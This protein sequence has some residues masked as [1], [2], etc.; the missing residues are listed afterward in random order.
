[1]SKVKRK[2]AD[3]S[4]ACRL[5]IEFHPHKPVLGPSIRC[6]GR[7]RLRQMYQATRYQ[8]TA[9]VVILTV[10]CGLVDS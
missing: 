8:S 4:A 6:I 2:F 1:M 7:A 5:Q 10:S 3:A 9:C